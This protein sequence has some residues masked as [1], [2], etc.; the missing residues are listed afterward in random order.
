MSLVIIGIKNK[1]NKGK[2]TTIRSVAEIM[3]QKYLNKKRNFIGEVYESIDVVINNKQIRIGI[4]SQGDPSTGLSKKLLE[5]VSDNCDVIIC[6]TRTSG[7]T[8][9]AVEEVIKQNKGLLI[10][11]STYNI[12][13]KNL[14][15]KMNNL[16]ANQIIELIETMCI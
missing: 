10:W 14:N 12:N 5:K 13:D 1:S 7:E 2:T 16:K 4:I 11:T 9:S 8:V 3:C 6:A 15:D